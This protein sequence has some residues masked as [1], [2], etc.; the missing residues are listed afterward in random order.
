M[1]EPESKVC[2]YQTDFPEYSASCLHLGSANGK[3]CKKM[4]NGNRGKTTLLCFCSRHSGS[5]FDSGGD[6]GSGIICNGVRYWMQKQPANVSSWD[7]LFFQT[8]VTYSLGT[9]GILICL[10]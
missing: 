9:S 4:E 10:H 3:H 6:N 2:V 7:S 1:A 8:A 5:I